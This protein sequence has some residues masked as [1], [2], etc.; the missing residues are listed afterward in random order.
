MLGMFHSAGWLLLVDGP[1]DEGKP[2]FAISNTGTPYACE[3]MGLGGVF[4]ASG[5]LSIGCFKEC[6]MMTTEIKKPPN[7]M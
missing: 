6:A 4:V 3:S 2:F 7:I 5:S 1:T